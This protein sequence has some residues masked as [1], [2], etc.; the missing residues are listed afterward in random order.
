[1]KDN[2]LVLWLLNMH[3][4]T[5]HRHWLYSDSLC[6]GNEYTCKHKLKYAVH[7]TLGYIA[8]DMVADFQ[9]QCISSV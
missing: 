7:V 2:T 8:N 9:V 5:K 1:L 6:V 4:A 3:F